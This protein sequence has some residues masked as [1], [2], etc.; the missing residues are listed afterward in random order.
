MV[1][2]VLHVP[3]GFVRSPVMLCLIDVDPL[4]PPPLVII[5]APRRH[6]RGVS[7]RGALPLYQVLDALLPSSQ[8]G[9]WSAKQTCHY[10][11]PPRI[12]PALQSVGVV[13]RTGAGKSSLAAALFRLVECEAGRVLLDGID[14]SAR[15]LLPSPHPTLSIPSLRNRPLSLPARICAHTP[16]AAG[17]GAS[18]TGPRVRPGHHSPGTCLALHWVSSGDPA[19]H[20]P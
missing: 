11:A 8:P 10:C 18:S 2:V 4:S 15:Q 13:G 7:W 17:L 12:I 6:F 19:V 20:T 5:S 14:V 3:R 1:G 16:V 9:L